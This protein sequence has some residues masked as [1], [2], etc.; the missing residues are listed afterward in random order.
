MAQMS[1]P[2]GIRTN[3]A[4]MPNTMGATSAQNDTR[5][6]ADKSMAAARAHPLLRYRLVAE[7]LA[8]TGLRATELCELAA[9]YRIVARVGIN[10]GIGHVHPHQLRHTLATEAI[11]RG[12]RL[13]AIAA[14]LGYRSLET[15]LVYARI[16]DR[17]V[18]DDYASVCEQ[19]DALY[20]TAA[21]RSRIRESPARRP[22]VRWAE[23]Q[24][25]RSDWMSAVVRSR[26][27]NG[28]TLRSVTPASA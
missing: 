18:A 6:R 14:L 16:A 17:V 27:P 7:M 2:L 28:A 15:T 5:P 3:I 11:S 9:V 4:M 20:N 1:E 19:I 10:A 24:V 8:R 12:M 23:G 13:E 22:V 21:T 25:E 26:S